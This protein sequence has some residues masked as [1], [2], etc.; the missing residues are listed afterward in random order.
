V[1]C[2][3]CSFCAI[4]KK[5]YYIIEDACAGEKEGNFE[6]RKNI[7]YYAFLYELIGESGMFWCLLGKKKAW[8]MQEVNRVHQQNSRKVG[9]KRASFQSVSSSVLL[10][11]YHCQSR[12]LLIIGIKC[13]TIVSPKNL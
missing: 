3:L 5:H 12:F 9:S 7:I 1:H 13:W 4:H 6:Y 8:R 11:R 10:L 2:S